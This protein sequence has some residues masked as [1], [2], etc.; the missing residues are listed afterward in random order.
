LV[1]MHRNAGFRRTELFADFHGG[2]F[3]PQQSGGMILV[4]R[5]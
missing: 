5:R 1:E 3:D 4:A 2:R